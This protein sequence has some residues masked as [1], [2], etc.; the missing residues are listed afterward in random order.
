M[1]AA[2]FT[3]VQIVSS[4]RWGEDGWLSSIHSMSIW[5]SSRIGWHRAA[6]LMDRPRVAHLSSALPEVTPHA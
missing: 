5:P 2:G 6:R 1:E 3:E 4:A